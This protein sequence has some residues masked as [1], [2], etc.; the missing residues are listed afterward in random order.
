MRQ[1][2][3]IKVIGA[4]DQGTIINGCIA[5]NYNGV[6]INGIII[7]PRC[8]IDNKKVS[9]VHYLPVV[10]IS[11]WIAFDF[12]LL[13]SNRVR[14]EAINKLQAILQKYELSS[15]LIKLL[16]ISE[17]SKTL[18]G[19]IKKKDDLERF[20]RFLFDM[21]I[22]S[23]DFRIIGREEMRRL[24]ETYNK[25]S[26]GIFKELKENKIK[27]FYLL[28]DWNNQTEYH[29]VLLREIRK[30]TFSLA[31]KISYG[32]HLSE[33][34]SFELRGNDISPDHSI[35]DFL[36]SLATL[37]SPH[38]EHLTQQFFW[39]FGRIG[40]ENHPENLESTFH[41]TVIDLI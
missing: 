35:N 17:L 28:E 11:D 4:I 6:P 12:W 20:N 18:D 40:V 14:N 34:S 33:L 39:N 26:K 21:N 32:V 13:F 23:M 25:V 15:S 5:E 22:T 1:I 16:S 24:I 19:I 8:D 37:K 7:T 27:Q 3:D 31:E 10:R 30:L 9:T 38:I 29:V 36:S 2:F 41:D